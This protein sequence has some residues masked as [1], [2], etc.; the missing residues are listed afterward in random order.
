MS[1]PR[2]W[3]SRGLWVCGQYGK[4]LSWGM[5]DYPGDAYRNWFLGGLARI[6]ALG[7]FGGGRYGK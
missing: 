2:L 6:Q 3:R 1:K 4:P 5:G 7:R